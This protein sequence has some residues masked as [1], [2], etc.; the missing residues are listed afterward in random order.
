MTAAP[1][2]VRA[3]A[4]R[5]RLVVLNY[6]GGEDVVRSVEALAALDWPADRREIVVVDNASGDGS[7]REV[8]RRV[9]EARLIRNAR[10]TGFPANNLALRDLDGIDY[11]GL[12]NLDA[13]VSPGWLVPLVAAL[14]ADPG[15][16]AAS[17]RLLFTAPYVDVTVTS[18]TSRAGRLDARRLGVLVSGA[19]VG[20]RDV[21]RDVHAVEGTWGIEHGDSGHEWWTSDRAVLRL[22]VSA[23]CPGSRPR[24]VLRLAAPS[25]K[26][27]TLRSGDAE[28]TVTVGADPGW[29][30]VPLAGEAR[31]I[32]NNAGTVVFADGYG[33]DRGFLEPAAG[34]YVEPDEVFAW[35]GGSV[36]LRPAYLADVGLFDERFFLYYEDTDLSWRGRRRG[37]R[38][39]YVPAAEV[40]H[41]LATSSGVATPTFQ[42][43]TERNRL[44]MLAKNAPAPMLARAIVRYALVTLSYARRDLV[45]PVLGGRRPRPEQVRRRLRSF[46]GFARL[47][48]AL[49]RERR[50]LARAA[51]VPE[52]EVTRG[53]TPR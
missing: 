45:A 15:L 43:Y 27:V 41:G 22:P 12:V 16:G 9:P 50:R 38:Y 53:L 10:N 1:G 52:A 3:P 21:W 7:D 28:V 51:T 23:D 46:A 18:P 40:R 42:H 33:A 13:V 39:R 26:P 4:P 29:F 30:D 44:A 36:L 48:P 2:P 6:N 49:W 17:A 31:D 47:A 19:R 35:S 5:V 32:L 24:G 37:W 14:E 11:V 20:D 34:R 25:T 8:A